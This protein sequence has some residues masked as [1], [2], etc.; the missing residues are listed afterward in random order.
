MQTS[1]CQNLN[2]S[3]L[4]SIK[5]ANFG[6]YEKQNFGAKSQVFRDARF[7]LLSLWRL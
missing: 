7:K 2:F 4:G 5:L 1:E 6:Q 3:L